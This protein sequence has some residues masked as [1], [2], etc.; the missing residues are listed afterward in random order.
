MEENTTP[1]PGEQLI[2]SQEVADTLKPLILEGI[3]PK[4]PETS[5]GRI[6]PKDNFLDAKKTV[7]ESV[8]DAAQTELTVEEQKAIFKQIM[9]ESKKK[10]TSKFFGKKKQM[11]SPNAAKKRKAKSKTQKNSRKANRK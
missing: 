6:Y 7:E 9:D 1:A 8:K 2:V 4:F 11:V 3:V 5:G 10:T